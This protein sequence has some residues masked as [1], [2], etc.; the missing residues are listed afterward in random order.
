MKRKSSIQNFGKRLADLRKQRGLTQQ[1]LA[2]L[3]GVS[4]R[5]VAY[6]EGETDYPPTHLLLP[7][8]KAVCVSIDELLGVKPFKTGLDPEKAALWRRL[9]KAEHLSPKDKK[10]L[11]DLLNAL[12]RKSNE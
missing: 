11:L 12:V 10:T 6:Y 9:K 8:A 2:D 4:K 5:V 7:F 3:S 1:K